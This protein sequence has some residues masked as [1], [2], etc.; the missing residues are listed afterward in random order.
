[1]EYVCIFAWMILL[2]F[3]VK[4]LRYIPNEVQIFII[5]FGSVFA[6]SGL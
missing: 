2:A 4:I 3:V 6:D 5:A 1:M